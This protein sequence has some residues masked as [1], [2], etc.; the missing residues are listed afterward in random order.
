MK[1][2]VLFNDNEMTFS[3]SIRSLLLAALV[4]ANAACVPSIQRIYHTPV[5]V[6]QV[7]DLET[8]EPIEGAIVKHEGADADFDLDDMIEASKNKILTNKQGEYILP[9]TSSVDAILLMPGYAIT[10]YPVRISTRNNSALVFA[11]ASMLMRDEETTGAPL[12]IMDPDPKTIAN[13]PP[14][15]YL[16][17]KIFH[18]YLYPHST[19]GKCDLGIGG[20]AISALNTARKVYWRHINEPDV[21]QE[22]VNAAYLNVR[23]IWQ[24]FYNSCDFGDKHTIERRDAIYAVR[25]ITDQI[26]QEVSDLTNKQ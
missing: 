19:L 26:K 10:D 2:R 17:Y 20:D 21:N 1:Q 5:V 12:L 14:G 4:L 24:Y 7:I 22:I 3:L 9:S 25:E 13:T 6:G 15:D 16:D 18:S 8:L 11:S 23:N